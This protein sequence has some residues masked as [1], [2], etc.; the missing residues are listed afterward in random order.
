MLDPAVLTGD[1]DFEDP[2][3]CQYY[4]DAKANLKWTRRAATLRPNGP[5]YDHTLHTLKGNSNIKNFLLGK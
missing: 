1:C 3:S 2:T 4:N 5:T